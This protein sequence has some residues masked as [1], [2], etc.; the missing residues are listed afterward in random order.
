[1]AFSTNLRRF[2]IT[3]GSVPTTNIRGHV[4]PEGECIYQEYIGASDIYSGAIKGQLSDLTDKYSEHTDY[5][6][7]YTDPAAPTFTSVSPTS[8]STAG[9]TS[10]TITGTNLNSASVAVTVGGAAATTVRSNATTITCSTPA[11]T[12]GAKPIVITTAEGSV[13]AASAFTYS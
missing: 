9:G 6:L 4:T 12:S 5:A 7:T 11:G 3:T 1:M 2:Q 10:I 8:G 13:T